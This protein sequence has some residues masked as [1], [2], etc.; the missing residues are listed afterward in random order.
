MMSAYSV[1][2]RRRIVSSV[3][4]GLPKAQAARTFS[5]S[6]SSVSNATC[7]GPKDGDRWLR[8]RSRGRSEARR[9]SHEALGGGSKGAPLRYPKRA[10]RVHR[11][12]D[13]ILG[14]SLHDVPRH[15]P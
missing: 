14:E 3:E 5:V 9:E 13:G 8:R 12:R 2:L 4:A 1:D 10:L 15:S 6:L 7:R 11:G